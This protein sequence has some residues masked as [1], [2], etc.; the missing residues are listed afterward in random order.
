[1]TF[2]EEI[3]RTAWHPTAD[4]IYRIVRKR[5]PHISLGTV[6]R[7]LDILSGCGMIQKLESSCSQKRFDGDLKRHCHVR[8]LVCGRMED[9]QV[10]PAEELEKTIRKVSRFEIT[11]HCLCFVGICPECKKKEK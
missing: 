8:C 4:E 1:M 10:R 5:L 7:N 11:G 3:N 2:L 6:Y 9:A